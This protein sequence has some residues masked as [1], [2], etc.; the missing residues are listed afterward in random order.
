M[1]TRRVKKMNLLT[2]GKSYVSPQNGICSSKISGSNSLIFFK[3]SNWKRGKV[4]EA[5]TCVGG[6]SDESLKSRA[7][8]NISTELANQGKLEEAAL[9]IQEAL[10][11]AKGISDDF[12]KSNSLNDISIELAKQGKVEEALTCA[13]GISDESDRIN[14]LNDISTELA[15]QGKL[16]E[17]ASAMQDALTCAMGISDEFWKS[18]ALE[19]ISTELA[20]Q[21][22]IEE[23]H[24][25]V[26]GISDE[27]L[28]SSAL[29]DISIELTKQ[30]NWSLAE[31]FG[32]DIL[33]TH[34]RHD[35][36]QAIAKVSFEKMGWPL[37]L[38][39]SVNLLTPEAKK[40]YIRSFSDWLKPFECHSE[41]F[42]NVRGYFLEDPISLENL[43]RQF[44][45][46][47][48]FFNKAPIIKLERINR[49][50]NIQWAID[51]KRKQIKNGKLNF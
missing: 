29:K 22:K 6:I 10:I 51:I 47:E 42:L 13:R 3:R 27:S 20:K 46:H 28:K 7:L 45:L 8:K 1:E 17:A 14:A 38:Q 18:L 5:L 21:G 34:E 44:A 9:A 40:H 39:F 37:A 35:C 23:A 36:W 41:L 11:C 15:K 48:L 33:Q 4:E 25:C 19:N 31:T 50:L 24:T 12:W 49:T 30:G 32:W 26:S 2:P 43:M 16:E